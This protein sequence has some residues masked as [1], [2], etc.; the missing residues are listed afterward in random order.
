MTSVAGARTFLHVDLDAFYASV[1]QLDDPTLR[2]RPVIVGGSMRG[3]VLAASYE[4]RPFG[5]KS[6]MPMARALPLC[7]QAVVVSPRHARYAELSDAFFAILE[8]YSPLVEGLSLDEAFLDVTG[9]EKLFGDGV[10][11]GRKIK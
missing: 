1:E 4:A 11:I 6:A 5:I 7:P 2:G 9:E 10:E 8:R 3:V